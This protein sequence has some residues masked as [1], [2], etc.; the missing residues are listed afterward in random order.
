MSDC[1][2]LQLRRQIFYGYLTLF[3]K[4]NKTMVK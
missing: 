3:I 1:I 2:E 4:K